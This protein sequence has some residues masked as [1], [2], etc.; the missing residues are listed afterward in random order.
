[1][2]ANL[3]VG[4]VT[5][6]VT[7]TGAASLLQTD[8]SEHGQIIHTE[9]IVE[10]PLNGRSSADLALLA[11]NVH[12]SPFSVAFAANATPREGSFNVSTVRL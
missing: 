2:D 7:V 11:T 10:L 5:E 8:S 12:R 9:Q 3:Q 1:V 6:V 4:L